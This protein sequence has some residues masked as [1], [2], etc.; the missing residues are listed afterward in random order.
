MTDEHPPA[1][2]IPTRNDSDDVNDALAALSDTPAQ[3]AIKAAHP[4]GTVWV[5]RDA[6]THQ[7]RH[8]T[9]TPTLDDDERAGYWRE[10]RI[11]PARM[12]S[13]LRESE[14]SVVEAERYPVDY[15]DV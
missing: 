12:R 2:G 13:L 1:R 9:W 8:S 4:F 6:D 14:F 11:Y 3:R 15:A 10:S 5:R 7:W